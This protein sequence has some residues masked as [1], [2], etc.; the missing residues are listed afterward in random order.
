MQSIFTLLL[1]LGGLSAFS[2]QAQEVT[3][4]TVVESSSSMSRSR[5][6]VTGPAGRTEQVEL[7]NIWGF[8]GVNL[9]NLEANDRTMQVLFE[10]LLN[11][12]WRLDNVMPVPG[13]EGQ[14]LTRYIYS[15]YPE[16]VPIDSLRSH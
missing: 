16:E 1:V 14:L 8:G 15:R 6:L 12:G 11:G 10:D 5:I 9:K 7:K 4:V 2:L 13:D 3:I